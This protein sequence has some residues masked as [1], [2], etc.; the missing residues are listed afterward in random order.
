M[1]SDL[2]HLIAHLTNLS[3]AGTK[4]ATFDVEFLLKALGQQ[5]P[6]TPT[7]QQQQ[8]FTVTDVDGGTFKD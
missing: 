1:S 4:Q 5:I 6:N 2:Q 7:K 8:P 3:N